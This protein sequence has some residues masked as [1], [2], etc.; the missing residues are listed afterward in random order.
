M[1]NVEPKIMHQISYARW[2]HDR[3]IRSDASER[4][5]VKVIEMRMRHEDKVNRRQ[6]MNFEPRPFQSFDHLEPFRPDWVDQDVHLVGLDKKRRVSDPGDTDLAFAD[7]R[8]F[9]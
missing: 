4:A 6:M 3:L 8:K 1:H 7:L 9:R 5:P 2:D